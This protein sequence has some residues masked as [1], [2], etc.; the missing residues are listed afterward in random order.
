M[1][2]RR[3]LETMA[4]TD[5]FNELVVTKDTVLK[6]SVNDLLDGELFIVSMHLND[7]TKIAVGLPELVAAIDLYRKLNSEDKETTELK[8]K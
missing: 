1:R 8:G 7:D 6:A 5:E 2:L 4:R 3:F